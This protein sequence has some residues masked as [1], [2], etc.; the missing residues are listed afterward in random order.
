M[1]VMSRPDSDSSADAMDNM[2]DEDAP[3]WPL[4]SSV[5]GTP[6]DGNEAGLKPPESFDEHALAVRSTQP[7]RQH[8][9]PQAEASASGSQLDQHHSSVQP[10]ARAAPTTSLPAPSLSKLSDD[11]TRAAVLAATSF[12]PNG[13]FGSDAATDSSS[14]IAPPL[15]STPLRPVA[16][17]SDDANTRRSAAGS[18]KV[19]SE[20]STAALG[21]ATVSS[22]KK[23]K[24]ADDI[25]WPPAADLLVLKAFYNEPSLCFQFMPR[26]K[27]AAQAVDATGG[28][29][30]S[31][32]SHR[33][34]AR[35][36]IPQILPEYQ[37]YK[38]LVMPEKSL[39][40][41]VGKY[42][43]SGNALSRCLFARYLKL[44]EK[45]SS[46]ELT[47]EEI[48]LL[49]VT[50]ARR[51]TFLEERR[52]ATRA[53]SWFE[54]FHEVCHQPR[55]TRFVARLTQM[56]TDVHKSLLK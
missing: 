26:S 55:I 37:D 9:M 36:L 48:E 27:D 11:A 49:S 7:G 38:E 24:R 45:M 5:D 3:Q 53:E 14:V 43:L 22:A 21:P 12:L 1:L 18:P 40:A 47:I 25:D 10:V 56:P 19:Q 20:T 8:A 28:S 17:P 35:R 51:M 32:E 44:A 42:W 23:R 6:V 54:L 52:A 34:A 29:T 39:H 31:H 15:H 4:D 46:R 33:D 2:C 41:R 13:A 30:G 50:D 16:V